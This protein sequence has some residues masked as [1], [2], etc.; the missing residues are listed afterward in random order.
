MFVFDSLNAITLSRDPEGFYGV[1]DIKSSDAGESW[2]YAE[3]SLLAISFA[4]DFRTTSEGW[5]ASGFKFLFTIDSG[6]TW[7]EMETPD[8]TVVFDLMFADAN[9][10]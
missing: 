2:S 9:N 1:G 4:I 10:G 5:S 7:K 3:L 8:G 6:E